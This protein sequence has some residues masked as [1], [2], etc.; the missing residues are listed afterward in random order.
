MEAASTSA[1]HAAGLTARLLALS[2]RQ[3]LD[4]RATD[5]DALAR[6]LDDLLRRTMSERI[7]VNI[8]CSAGL[9]AA[10]VDA[11]QLESAILALAINTHDAMP[12][13]GA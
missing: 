5:I 4:S 9:P 2:R 12:E 3:S 6:S 8:V 10:I 11:N 13:G 1:Q 7:L